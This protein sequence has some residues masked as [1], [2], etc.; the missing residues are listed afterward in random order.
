MAFIT[1]NKAAQE[2]RDL[3]NHKEEVADLTQKLS[4]R[5]AEIKESF[6]AD[7]AITREGL[8]IELLRLDIV[9]RGKNPLDQGEQSLIQGQQNEIGH[10]LGLEKTWLTEQANIMERLN[11][12]EA[13]LQT[14]VER[15]QKR[16]KNT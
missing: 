3:Q 16:S 4:Q 5:K 6:T 7:G 1:Q 14:L 2:E 12:A 11:E 9:R 8:N 15:K 10:L 13:E